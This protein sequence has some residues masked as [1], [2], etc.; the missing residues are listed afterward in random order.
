MMYLNHPLRITP[1]VSLPDFSCAATQED[2]CGVLLLLWAGEDISAISPSRWLPVSLREYTGYCTVLHSRMA[3]SEED[4]MTQTR[5]HATAHTQ[6]L[7]TNSGQMD[8]AYVS[9]QILQVNV[10]YQRVKIPVCSQC[11]ALCNHE[12]LSQYKRIWS[13]SLVFCHLCRWRLGHKYYVYVLLLWAKKVDLKFCCHFLC[14]S[15][16]NCVS[17]TTLYM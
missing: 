13:A 15:F 10:G 2:G 5:I 1:A 17:K 14:I 16:S 12:L 7:Q 11:S 9:M 8:T 6:S 3:K 4:K